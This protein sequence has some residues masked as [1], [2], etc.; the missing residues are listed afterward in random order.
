MTF[1]ES[2]VSL[3]IDRLN[4]EMIRGLISSSAVDHRFAYW[5]DE[6]NKMTSVF[7]DSMPSM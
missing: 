1:Y 4:G 5:S 7:A 3:T 2:S 6:T